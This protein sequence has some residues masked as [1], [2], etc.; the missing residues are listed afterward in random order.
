[1]GCSVAD[2]SCPRCGGV[3]VTAEVGEDFSP[4]RL[5]DEGACFRGLSGIYECANGSKSGLLPAG[6]FRLQPAGFESN[7]ISR[8]PRRG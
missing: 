8:P 2:D 7:V 1:M 3:L 5:R 4:G 6:E